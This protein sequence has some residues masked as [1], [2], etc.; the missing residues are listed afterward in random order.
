[1]IFLILYLG[2]Y[3]KKITILYTSIFLFL[4]SC[5]VSRQSAQSTALESS[6]D[7]KESLKNFLDDSGNLNCAAHP[8]ENIVLEVEIEFKDKQILKAQIAATSKENRE[9]FKGREEGWFV[10]SIGIQKEKV[11][12]KGEN[13]SISVSESFNGQVRETLE[14]K[15][16]VKGEKSDGQDT[17]S[18]LL[19]YKPG[20]KPVFINGSDDAIRGIFVHCFK[21]NKEVSR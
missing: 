21:N 9:A 1:M 8:R 19:T 2:V 10:K 12:L 20:T 5:A 6:S 7:D 4:Q 14:I 13:K 11:D 16:I 3:V 15:N 18:G 17:L